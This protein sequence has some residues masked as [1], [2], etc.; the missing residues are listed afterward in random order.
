MTPIVLLVI[1]VAVAGVVP[2]QAA[3]Y[4]QPGYETSG[5]P[6]NRLL[7]SCI[8]NA[9]QYYIRY[10]YSG[11]ITDRTSVTSLDPLAL[12]DATLIHT[13]DVLSTFSSRSTTGFRNMYITDVRAD[14][15]RLEFYLQ[16]HVAAIDTRG[17][18]HARL[19]RRPEIAEWSHMTYSIRNC[20][21]QLQLKGVNYESDDRVY[22]KVN[23]TD[24]SQQF[25]DHTVG[26]QWFTMSGNYSQFSDQFEQIRGRDILPVVERD[27]KQSLQ[28]RFQLLLNEILRL[29]PFERFFP[30]GY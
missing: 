26:F 7:N 2:N 20:S 16:F 5:C 15:T 21:I 28:D 3:G 10:L 23:V 12:P 30:T 13:N 24:F 19:L 8:E 4:T 22:L 18:Y 11:S 17:S 6:R 25:G 9:T 27:L 1:V 29:A 14:I